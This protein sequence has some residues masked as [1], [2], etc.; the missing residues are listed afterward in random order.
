LAI[1]AP[2]N[3]EE[4]L[5]P[6]PAGVTISSKISDYG[7]IHWFV[8]SKNEME[9]ELKKVLSL[10]KADVICWIYFPKSTSKIQTDL[11]RDKGWDALMENKS[12]QWLSL[13]S[14]D[15][16]WSAFAIRLQN[17]KD[18]KKESNPAGKRLIFDYADSATKTVRLPDDLAGAM[19]KSKK[20]K[21]FYETLSFSNKREYV[22]W[23]LTAKREETRNERVKGTIDRLE[24]GWKNPR[25]I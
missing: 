20:A 15:N 1:N 23:V 7:Q 25:N 18:I 21:D 13:V 14:F 11:T 24:K 8:K 5:S 10:L 2:S 22:E 17:P 9:K 6:L 3:F 4:H 19:K 12:L 16:T